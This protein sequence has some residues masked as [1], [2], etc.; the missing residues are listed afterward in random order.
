MDHRVGG[1]PRLADGH[2]QLAVA[3]EVRQRRRGG[4]GVIRELRET[5]R[6]LVAVNGHSALMP[7]DHFVPAVAIHVGHQRRI[8]RRPDGGGNARKV[9]AG[10]WRR[11]TA[12][13]QLDALAGFPAQP[14]GARFGLDED[15]LWQFR[16]G[17]GSLQCQDWRGASTVLP[18][19]LLAVFALHLE[20]A[21]ALNLGER[22]ILRDVGQQFGCAV[23]VHVAQVGRHTVAN[24]RLELTGQRVIDTRLPARLAVGGEQVDHHLELPIAVHVGDRRVRPGRRDR[25]RRDR[26][27]PAVCPGSLQA[28]LLVE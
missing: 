5:F 11:R 20:Q 18:P 4:G 6:A 2:F 8:Q 7:V 21:S 1:R 28:A 25:L 13:L 22:R 27:V 9:G 24:R 17:I 12:F 3:I 26:G 10:R 15:C 14:P 16:S 19:K 23:P